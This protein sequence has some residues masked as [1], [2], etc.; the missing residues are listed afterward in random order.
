MKAIVRRL[1]RLEDQARPIVYDRGQTPAEV[2]RARRRLR[3]EAAG[4][5][6]KTG[7][8]GRSPA[9]KRSPGPFGWL[10]SGHRNPRRRDSNA[11]RKSVAGMPLFPTLPRSPLHRFHS[12]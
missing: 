4:L 8:G 10:V 5:H 6:S 2:V 12:P 11:R 9:P 3:L 7:R 1:R